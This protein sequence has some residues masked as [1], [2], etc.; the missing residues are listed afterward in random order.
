[1]EEYTYIAFISYSHIDKDWAKWL[2]NEL[3]FYKLPAYIKEEYPLS[4]DYLRPVFR[5]ET[6]LKLGDLG[7][8][9]KNSLSSSRFLILICSSN[10]R[11]SKYVSDEI[12][13]FIE[14]GRVQNIIPFVVEQ[15]DDVNSLFPDPLLSL[16]KVPLAANINEYSRDYAF[17][18]VVSRLLG[19][20]E[21]HKLWDRYQ[22]AKEK[23]TQRIKAE[24]DHL[25]S[26]HSKLVFQQVCRL[27]DDNESILATRLSIALYPKTEE[28]N[29]DYPSLPYAEAAI[30]AAT[31]K[32]N[33]TMDCIGDSVDY[34]KGK[35]LALVVNE[36]TV[37]LLDVNSGG[38]ISSL[39]IPDY[40]ELV[41]WDLTTGYLLTYYYN[42]IR[43][44]E[45]WE[46][47]S[48]QKMHSFRGR[49]GQFIVLDGR[50]AI[51]IERHGCLEL[52][53]MNGD[54]IIS[55]SLIICEDETL[56]S[57]LNDKMAAAIY[58]HQGSIV[59][60]DIAGGKEI[61]LVEADSFSRLLSINNN[62]TKI[63]VLSPY[64]NKT[65]L[66]PD[67]RVEVYDLVSGERI[68]SIDPPYDVNR[69]LLSP[70]DSIL[71]VVA[72]GFSEDSSVS[73]FNTGTF[74]LYSTKSGQ[75]LYRK[76]TQSSIASFAFS[77]DSTIICIGLEN[78]DIML[79]SSKY[80]DEEDYAVFKNPGESVASTYAYRSGSG[81]Q[82]SLSFSEDGEHLLAL[83]KSGRIKLFETETY[84]YWDV[85][86][87]GSD[88]LSIVFNSDG[89]LLTCLISTGVL[90]TYDTAT[91]EIVNEQHL[92]SFNEQRHGK[93][94]GKM[95]LVAFGRHLVSPNGELI[96][97]LGVYGMCNGIALND[98]AD[99]VF[100]SF[101]DPNRITDWIIIKRIS[102]DTLFFGSTDEGIYN[103]TFL[104]DTGQILFL[105][106]SGK[107]LL[108]DTDGNEYDTSIYPT[109]SSHV[110]AVSGDSDM[111][112]M[113]LDHFRIGVIDRR[114]GQILKVLNGHNNE[115]TFLS[116]YNEETLISAGMDG[117][118][119]VWNIPAGCQLIT[120]KTAEDSF[121]STE[122]QSVAI[123][124]DAKYIA[125]GIKD[126]TILIKKIVPLEELVE[127]QRQRFDKRPLTDEEKDIYGL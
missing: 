123:S 104:S 76:D 78:G 18:K 98:S 95:R 48:G 93:I 59:L 106:N 116:F 10:T 6:D 38:T 51:L 29:K 86:S 113:G 121:E 45:M 3:E 64:E 122:I 23:E 107:F 15:T 22:L 112:S 1:M 68:I 53:D 108:V 85:F 126:G 125:I 56:L 100:A 117:K 50:I 33:G 14:L 16:T 101:Y 73:F 69:A 21:I 71:L 84:H 105:N 32:N 61:T 96:E 54:L 20:I 97:S 58:S 5:D 70:D 60:R 34:F 74:S 72:G 9:I 19:G 7:D 124:P 17:V 77:N 37:S 25:L 57:Y 49:D 36:R 94:D 30:R 80:G 26:I 103:P 88:L 2:Q 39:V 79:M 99:T 12:K 82:N 55:S 44:I 109:S 89:P 42:G 65:I 127:T 8:S 46:L 118:V 62:K 87:V 40:S 92:G 114:S 31:E 81:P 110:F 52:W 27:V 28:E 75:L 91:R 119:I 115:I 63:V 90:F 47:A 41:S 102:G 120:I 67:N 4:P 24:R 111:I 11:K 43:M 83:F 13:F 66:S 35:D